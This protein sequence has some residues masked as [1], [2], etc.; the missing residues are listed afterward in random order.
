[1][2][3]RLR[4][5][6][7]GPSASQIPGDAPLI[8]A[9]IAAMATFASPSSDDYEPPRWST[10]PDPEVAETLYPGFAKGSGIDGW[11]VV[12][13][14][15]EVDGHPFNCRAID[16]RPYG[17]GFGSAGR[18]VVA[19]G[20]IR[21]PRYLGEVTKG[22]FRARVNFGLPDSHDADDDEGQSETAW[23]ELSQ[24]QLRLAR[25][26][27]DARFDLIP[28]TGV[29]DVLDGLDYDRRAIVQAWFDELFPYD[30]KERQKETLAIQFARLFS[31]D[32]LRRQLRGE[33]VEEPSYEEWVAACPKPTPEERAA[34]AELIRRYC[35]QFECEAT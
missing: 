14:F 16:E 19:S 29:S 1:M 20:V 25:E 32:D 11:A 27:V 12:E 4:M 23:G 13:C 28:K 18:A 10:P 34:N 2:D 22:P 24:E 17:L 15:V 9:L 6:I 5:G 3:S 33:A 8:L 26:L 30:F 31:A 7:I 35:E 21:A